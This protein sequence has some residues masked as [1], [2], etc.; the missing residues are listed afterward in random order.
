M[1]QY[2][3]IDPVALDLGFFQ[4]R[5]Y[6][7]AYLGGF[8]GGWWR[9]RV[10]ADKYPKGIRPH[11]DDIE[12]LVTWVVLG[13]I[14]GGRL[15]YVLF[16]NFEYYA[17]HLSEVLA[18]WQGGMSFHGGLIGVILAIV[19]YC[20][21]Q[22]ISLLRTGDIVSAVVPIGLGLGRLSNFIN[23]EL[24]GRTTDMPWGMV[25][26]GG[27]DAPRHPSQLYQAFFEGLVLYLI[28]NIMMSKSNCRDKPGLVT[29]TFFTC[30]G[31][32]RFGVE[33]VRQPDPQIGFILE[34]LSMGQILSLPM[35]IFGAGLMI[36]AFRNAKSP[37]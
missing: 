10:L 30:Y 1:L 25:F 18:I 20:L 4:L 31:L 23:G 22:K 15:G 7:L 27:G 14:F 12:N 13:V 34:F 17:D 36:Y 3:D 9:A 29:G 19:G 28:L 32:A 11:T 33:F 6:A 8:L 5:W 21:V 2:P 16:Y 26:P 24:Y 35:I 37:S